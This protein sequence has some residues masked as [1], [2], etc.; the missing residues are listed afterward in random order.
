M[1]DKQ[2]TILQ[3]TA[4]KNIFNIAMI[5]LAL[6]SVTST[7]ALVSVPAQAGAAGVLAPRVLNNCFRTSL[8]KSLIIPYL[9]TPKQRQQLMTT[10]A[11]QQAIESMKLAYSLENN[12]NTCLR[13]GR[14]INGFEKK[15]VPTLVAYPS[16]TIY[17]AKE[18]NFTVKHS[19]GSFDYFGNATVNVG[20]SPNKGYSST[21]ELLP[22]IPKS[23][24]LDI[25]G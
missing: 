12:I 3:S 1:L 16:L 8:D 24:L 2:I 23:N 15:V 19:Q 11:S 14:N 18:T 22:L 4:M 25:K 7:F 13:F 21:A 10:K 6:T 20:Y 5:S 17:S 9:L